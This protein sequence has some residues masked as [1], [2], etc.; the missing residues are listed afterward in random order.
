MRRRL[1]TPIA[2][3]FLLAVGLGLVILLHLAGFRVVGA[4]KVGSP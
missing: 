1:F 4:L 2:I 3:V